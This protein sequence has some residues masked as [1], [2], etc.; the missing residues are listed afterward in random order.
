MSPIDD[1]TLSSPD[2]LNRI[3]SLFVVLDTATD[4]AKLV[5]KEYGTNKARDTT[6]QIPVDPDSF[7]YGHPGCIIHAK[8]SVRI[9]AVSTKECSGYLGTTPP[10][11][12]PL[13]GASQ[14]NT[15]WSTVYSIKP[16]WSESVK[17]RS[18]GYWGNKNHE[19]VIE[20]SVLKQW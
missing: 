15:S 7:P 8:C 20:L 19:A 1:V 12:Q 5:D 11:L 2:R 3:T 10:T 9:T 4:A 13:F 6:L 18:A 14:L 16:P 17:F